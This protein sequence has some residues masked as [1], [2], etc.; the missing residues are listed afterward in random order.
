S[1]LDGKFGLPIV[2]V[3]SVWNSW[4]LLK[5]GFLE[6]LKEV[7][8]KPMA[9]NLCKFSMMKLK[10]SSA[11]GAANLGARHIGYDLPMDYA[12]NVDIFFE[13]CFKL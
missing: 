2:C 1:L 7:K 8:Q 11:V 13:H 10:C 4:D 9:K 3:G 6:V 12:N 5:N